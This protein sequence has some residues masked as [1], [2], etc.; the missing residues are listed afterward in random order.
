MSL[1]S[2]ACPGRRRPNREPVPRLV[3]TSLSKAPRSHHRL[4]AFTVAISDFVNGDLY[5]ELTSVANSVQ[6][7]FVDL[8]RSY[9][10][11]RISAIHFQR[12]ISD[13]LARFKFDLDFL[14]ITAQLDAFAFV[15]GQGRALGFYRTRV[16][17]RPGEQPILSRSATLELEQAIFTRK[18]F[19]VSQQIILRGFLRRQ[20]VN[21]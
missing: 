18:R 4:L 13:S 1:Q 15:P 7:H 17:R 6:E 8:N 16:G 10:C 11:A 20:E 12:I 5:I 14:R 19:G 2:P 21:L 9:Q 3:L